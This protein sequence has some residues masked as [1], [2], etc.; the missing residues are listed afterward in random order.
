LRCIADHRSK[1]SR[2]ENTR[3]NVPLPF[4]SETYA[5]VETVVLVVAIAIG[6]LAERTSD[7]K[8][9]DMTIP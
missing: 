2:Q 8:S 1:V 5:T 9:M 6:T 7:D 4:G 3:E